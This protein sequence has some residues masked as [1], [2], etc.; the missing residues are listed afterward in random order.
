MNNF[1]FHPDVLVS[2]KAQ[3][4]LTL[5]SKMSTPKL[6]LLLLPLAASTQTH[7][8]G[9]Q[10][11][12]LKTLFSEEYNPLFIPVRNASVQVQEVL[13]EAK[14]EKIIDFDTEKV[15]KDEDYGKIK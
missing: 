14:L 7:F 10:R 3:L 2:I 5:D 13:M 8:P 12:L 1:H 6:L 15:G 9:H 4:S 11:N